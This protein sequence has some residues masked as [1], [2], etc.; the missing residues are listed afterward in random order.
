MTRQPGVGDRRNESFRGGSETRPYERLRDRYGPRT[1]VSAILTA[2]GESTRMGQP[3]PLLRWHGVPLIEY[4]TASLLGGGAAEVVA[5]LGHVHSQVAPHVTGPRVR[6]VVNERYREGKT[7]S[8]KAGLRSVSSEA[9]AITLLAVDQPR[10]PEIVAAVVEAHLESKALITSPRYEG[11]GGHPLVFAA[12]LRD[13]LEAMTEEG[14]GI[15][16]V[17]SAHRGDVNEVPID[18][19]IV[20]LDLNSPDGYEAARVRYGA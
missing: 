8:I 14:Q 16:A 20:R 5:V 1:Y 12:S 15:R 11:H 19:R 7:T 9:T 6:Y 17:F 10:P 13:E 18:D 4:Q 2:A 3:K